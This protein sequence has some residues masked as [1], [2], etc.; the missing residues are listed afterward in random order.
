MEQAKVA[1][2]AIL[3]NS[4]LRYEGSVVATKLKVAGI[5]LASIGNFYEE[6]A[7]CE[8]LVYS[9][10][11]VSLYKKAVIQGGRVVGAILLGDLED[12]NRFYE[13][14]KIGKISH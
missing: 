5:P 8:A 13:Y 3:G 9:D 14:I 6:S 12:Y 11:G 1:A 4:T 10:P 7:G 2:D